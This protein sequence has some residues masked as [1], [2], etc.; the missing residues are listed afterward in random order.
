[1][2]R[3]LFKWVVP[4]LA[5][6]LGGTVLCLALTSA[7]IAN[8]LTVQATAAM[9]AAGYQWAELST[10]MRDVSLTGTTTSAANRD[11]AILRLA[12]IP[13]VRA[14]ATD[15]TL[16]PTASPYILTASL[17]SSGIKLSGGVPDEAT[18][19]RLLT[20]ANLSDAPIELRSGMP[21]RRA[22]VAGAEFA[23]DQLKYFDQAE[24]S[25][26]DLTV[27]LSGRAKS[28]RD[29]RDLLIVMRA[30][31]PIGLTLGSVEITPAL[32]SPYQWSAISDGTKIS[33]TGFAP[34]DAMVE[35]LH[36]AEAGGLPIA[37]GL[38]LGSGEP[39]GFEQLS[40][41]LIE[42]LARLEYGTASITDGASHLSG[43]PPTAE[44]A[45]IVVDELAPSGTIVVL[46]P[47]RIADYWVSA[48]LQ[49]GGALVFDGYV[50]DEVTRESLAQ[51]PGADTT[52]L[53]I[54]RGAP[55]RYQS[56]IEFGL[57]VT[58]RLSEGRFALRD[59]VVTLSGI[60]RSGADYRALLTDLAGGPPQGLILARAEISA[61]Q[62]AQYSWQAVK[63]PGGE[64]VLLGM[65]PSPEAKAEML[66]TFGQSTTETM[67]YASGE[68]RNFLASIRT[69][70]ALLDW[71]GEGQV[72]YD[73]SGWTVTG[74]AKS[75]IAKAAIDADFVTRQ[76]AATGW[77]MAVATPAP[78]IPE[79]S[80]VPVAEPV[81]VQAIQE[82]L[83]VEPVAAAE[84]AA[85]AVDPTYA[86]SASRAA[87]GSIVLSGQLPADPAMRYFAAITKGDTAAVSIA[88]GAPE[89]FLAS[90]ETGLR[91]LLQLS[92][93]QLDFTQGNWALSGIAETEAG[94]EA[95]I[96]A[97]AAA[98]GEKTWKLEIG[99]PEQAVAAITPAPP[100]PV[101]NRVDIA[102][103]Q[104]RIDDFSAQNAILFQSGA[105][106]IAT[107]SD[108]ALDQL[109]ID[110]ARCPDAVV[111]VEGHTDADGDERLNLALSVARAEA[112]VSALI[113]RGI[114]P[115]RLYAVGYGESSPVAE[116]DT[117]SG[118][119]LNR[120][121]VVT[122]SDEHY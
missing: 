41:S 76:L 109:A 40:R 28:Q 27:S 25:V 20:R 113:D 47:P 13:G 83:P 66:E 86:F 31:A 74:T 79:V 101:S 114:T 96:A 87:D 49:A 52:W 99:V 24:I 48:T 17:D 112:V 26:S 97:I 46:E 36:T 110:L 64:I 91:A 2:I 61:P 34:D 80:P 22:W 3:D 37:T 23:I 106:I 116:N 59:N 44:I 95:V 14:I 65:V 33:V 7:N 18:R 6:V 92:E 77:S 32:V 117:A 16:A 5:T 67:T 21:G 93:G 54:G 12:A 50:P 19:Q 68:P 8:D 1:M 53:K 58:D 84:P 63:Q 105:A 111:H 35:R 78:A 62:A 11:D 98:P 104:G 15:I 100:A 69:A 89:G 75:A 60:A 121:I 81:E 42:Q 45:Q 119:R 30:G 10:D 120:R 103:C 51:H 115:T 85:P 82:P 56:A 88:T 73:G 43:A 55:E 107:E 94:R 39:A 102:A 4:G 9:D 71:L 122:V 118:K 29:F 90:A 57:S 38:A 108:P 70:V 72:A